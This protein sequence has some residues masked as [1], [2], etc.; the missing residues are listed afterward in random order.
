MTAPADTSRA[1]APATPSHDERLRNAVHPPDWVNPTPRDRYHLVVI[2]A[3]TAGLVTAAGAA[4]LGAKVALIER[5]LMGGDC[6]NVGCVPSK[7]LIAPARAWAAARQAQELFGG[8]AVHGDGD[9][10]AVMERMRRLRADIA[11]IDGAER[12]RSL[13]VDVFLGQGTFVSGHEIE[14]GGAR[15]RFRRAVIATGARAAAPPIPGLADTPYLTNETLFDLT[16]RPRHLVVLGGG[17]IGC[18]MAQAFA[19]LGA[20]V[21][22]L[23]RGARL[24]SRDDADASAVVH[25]ALECDGVRVVL[26][27][28]I[29]R[30]RHRDGEFT[31]EASAAGESLVLRADQLLVAAGRAPNV[32]GLGLDRA[33]VAVGPS[34]VEVTDRLQTS[35]PRIF[36]CGD[37]C[38][39][40]QFT[41]AA[42]FQARTVIQNALF[43][44]RKKASALVVPWT[45]YTSP[46]VASVGLTAEAAAAAG[47]AIDTVTVPMHDV[48]RAILDGET[49]GFA[50]V[51]LRRGTDR[52]VGATI[53]AAHAGDLLAEVTLCMTNTLGLGAIGATMHPYPTQGDALRRCADAWRKTRLTP[54]VRALFARWFRLFS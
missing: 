39:R 45:T 13:G 27:A 18:E 51:R 29:A 17:P 37:V 49:D 34:G 8:P 33:G 3:G 7:G 31:V 44:G 50:R 1:Q 30:V 16:T 28:E 2:G 26:G 32:E 19:R 10:A 35:N 25:R 36:A 38:S 6:L 23:D 52:I 42:D 54:T 40:L 12:F 21:T 41:H 9:F 47:I 43:F 53:V 4:G 5:H 14:V 20:R 22:L 48:D 46:E 15:L 24:L 11:P